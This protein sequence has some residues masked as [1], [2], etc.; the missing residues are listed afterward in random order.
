M[1]STQDETHKRDAKRDAER[2]DTRRNDGTQGKTQGETQ[3]E[4]QNGTQ[5]GTQD[6]T[7]GETEYRKTKRNSGEQ[8]ET[9]RIYPTLAGEA[10]KELSAFSTVSKYNTQDRRRIASHGNIHNTNTNHN[11]NPYIEL[12]FG[13]RA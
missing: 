12:V 7:N 1:N 11:G 4:T 8:N 2:Y 9:A 6:E 3:G 10:P 13:M 5:N